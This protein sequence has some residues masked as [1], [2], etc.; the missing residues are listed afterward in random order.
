MHVISVEMDHIELSRVLINVL[1][2][3]H[4]ECKLIYATIVQPQSPPAHSGQP[5]LR[6]RIS[7]GKKGD[8][9]SL[10]DQFL[11]QIGNYTFSSAIVPG[12]DALIKG[13]YLGY[14]H[15]LWFFV[16]VVDI[17]RFSRKY[18]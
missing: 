14:F 16:Y 6:Y 11:R 4:V 3:Q 1:Q 17:F 12:G 7:A 9:V 13:R 5:C 10:P 2:K 15:V 18:S 8:L